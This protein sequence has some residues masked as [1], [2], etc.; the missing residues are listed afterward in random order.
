LNPRQIYLVWRS[1]R[2]WTALSLRVLFRC[3]ILDL[4]A[5]EPD[6]QLPEPYLETLSYR[7][8]LPA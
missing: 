7:P 2:A 1:I 8:R 6:V 3:P 5:N 4:N